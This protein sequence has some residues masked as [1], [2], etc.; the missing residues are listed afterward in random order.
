MMNAIIG[1]KNPIPV[2]Y[3]V[4]WYWDDILPACRETVFLLLRSL[5]R[6]N[7]LHSSVLHNK[8]FNA[9]FSILIVIVS[10]Y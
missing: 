3:L 4:N 2:C 6:A 9:N 1:C 10:N 7:Y 8:T 5:I